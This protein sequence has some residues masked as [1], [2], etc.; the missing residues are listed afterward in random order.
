LTARLM[1]PS[2]RD[3]FGLA[4]GET[5]RRAARQL[6]LGSSAFTRCYRHGC[7]TL[8]LIMKQPVG[9]LAGRDPII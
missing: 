3:A 9:W 1:P 2:L 8:A 4:Y 5:Q 6:T 7:G